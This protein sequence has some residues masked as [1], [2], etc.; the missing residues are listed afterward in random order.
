MAKKL[1]LPKMVTPG[2][3]GKLF[4]D[5]IELAKI[6]DNGTTT[7]Y[8]K[9]PRGWKCKRKGCPT[10]FKHTHSTYPSLYANSKTKK[11]S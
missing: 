8:V 2:N 9:T 10:N 3:V 6:V 1:K 4:N 7:V 11:S 5:I